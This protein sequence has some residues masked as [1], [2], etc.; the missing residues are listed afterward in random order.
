MLRVAALLVGVAGCTK[1]TFAERTCVQLH[2]EQ[3]QS[4]LP[5][6]LVFA[7]GADSGQVAVAASDEKTPAPNSGFGG[8]H[9]W[10]RERDSV[11]VSF[12]EAH[13]ST[14]Y[15]LAGLPDSGRG[16][17]I[18]EVHLTFGDSIANGGFAHTDTIAVTARRLDCVRLPHGLP[19]GI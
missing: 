13:G 6:F 1:G 5:D 15:H 18:M 11:V 19:P 17:A 12:K 16:A 3:M 2:H 10:H 7:P 9:A 8:V 14:Q 4:V